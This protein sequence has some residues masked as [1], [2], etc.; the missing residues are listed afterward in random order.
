MLFFERSISMNVVAL[1]SPSGSRHLTSH[2]LARLAPPHLHAP[3]WVEQVVIVARL[4][5]YWNATCIS[6]ELRRRRSL[7]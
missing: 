5:T 7:G 2:T 6:A 4:H 1:L 3:L